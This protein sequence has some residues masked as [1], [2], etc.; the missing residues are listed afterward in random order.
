MAGE[1]RANVCGY[2]VIDNNSPA[3]LPA[4]NW[5]VL[6]TRIRAQQNAGLNIEN[7]A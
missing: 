7:K 4:L 5:L 3:S 6:T 2:A 1:W